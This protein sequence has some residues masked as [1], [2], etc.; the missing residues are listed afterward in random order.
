VRNHMAGFPGITHGR[1]TER[2]KNG[3]PCIRQANTKLQM[4][5]AV[6]AA[7]ANTMYKYSVVVGRLCG[8]MQNFGKCLTKK[9]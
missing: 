2:I 1:G 6:T 7:S 3:M 9:Y 8:V 4:A 5:Y